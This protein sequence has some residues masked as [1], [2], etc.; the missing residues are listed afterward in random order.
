MSPLPP[1]DAAH[2]SVSPAVSAASPATSVSARH[3]AGRRE[4]SRH[5]IRCPRARPRR[6]PGRRPGRRR[7]H[8]R[9]RQP[10]HRRRRAVPPPAGGP[11]RRRGRRRAGPRASAPTSSW[12]APRRRWSPGS[13][14]PSA[15]RASP[16]SARRPRRR[17]LEGSK[18]FAKEVMAAAG[19]PT[20]LAHV[21]TTADEVGRRARRVRRAVR[22]QGRRPG[23][24]QGRRRHRRPRRGAGARAAPAST[25]RRPGRHRGVPR[26]PRGVAVLP[27][28]TARPSCRSR[29]PRTSSGSATATTGPNTG[30]M[31]AYSPLRWA[32]AG[33]VD[34]V[35]DARRPA[36]GRR[37]AP[38][39]HPVRRRPLRRPGADPA[40][41]AGH[42]VQRPLRRPRDPGRARPAARPRSAGCCMAAATGALDE[43][44]RRCAGASDA[45]VTVVVAAAQLPRHPAH[46]R[47]DHGPRRGRRRRAHGV[48]A[49]RRH[50]ARRRRR[51]GLRRR[52]GAVRRRRSA[53]DLA[54]ARE[55]AYDAVARST[56]D[57]LAPPHRHR[58]RGR[59]WR[60]D[61]PAA[62]AEGASATVA[63]SSCELVRAPRSRRSRWTCPAGATST[64]ARCATST[65][66]VEPSTG[67]SARGPL[68]LVAR[69]RISAY[70]YVLDTAIPD[71]GAVLTQLS[72]WWFEQLAD[73]VPNHVVVHATCPP[74][75]PAGPCWCKRLEMLPVE[76][77]ARAYLTGGGLGEYRADRHRLRR[78]AARGPRGRLPAARADL[79]P[80]DQGAGRASTTRTMTYAQVEAEIG[81]DAGRA[82]ARAHRWR[83]YGAATRSPR[84]R[85]IILADTKVEF[86]LD[87]ATAHHARR[88]GADPGLVAVLAGRPW[89]PGRAQP[90]YDK[91]YVRDWLTSPASGWD[92][93]SGE[94]AAPAAGRRRRARPGPVRRGLR[95]AHRPHVRM[96]DSPVETPD[97][98]WSSST[99]RTGG[100]STRSGTSGSGWPGRPTTSARCA[101]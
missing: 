85:G 47:P 94:A 68:L 38:P 49:A 21:C 37:D 55:R 86:G 75:S 31:G 54:E 45:A 4:G 81:A 32:P 56:L 74:R 48:R 64:P 1:G 99:T 39:R 52:P 28:A 97:S 17:R 43:R 61:R 83:S 93:S 91:Q 42:R 3:L 77:V 69:D 14:T 78:P 51:A 19:V 65:P 2:I 71:K 41:P 80:V 50:R 15:P 82:G 16:A 101:A 9:P 33:L 58:A 5:R 35:V 20:A 22:R 11:A 92:R 6:G 73:L 34:E 70:D 87:A 40:R 46:R 25:G 95:A 27:H 89:E 63:R 10:R 60:G 66:R 84:E 72:L 7:R 36:D 67:A 18:A 90:S 88:R 13:P 76:C 8:R 30:G 53:T 57:G 98:A 29:R 12:S 24:R 59:A 44:R 79:H 26:R 62:A 96:S 100:R 23:R